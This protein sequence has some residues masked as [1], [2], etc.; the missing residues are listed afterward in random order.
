MLVV[1]CLQS[2][3]CE[4]GFT[5]YNII[6]YWLTNRLRTSVVNDIMIIRN[7][8]WNVQYVVEHLTTDIVKKFK[9]IKERRG[10]RENYQKRPYKKRKKDNDA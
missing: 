1:L 9:K 5:L 3:N 6:C 2:T 8:N 10:A 4:R 7:A